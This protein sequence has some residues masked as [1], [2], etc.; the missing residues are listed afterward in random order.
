MSLQNILY[1]TIKKLGYHWYRWG[2]T[3][4]AREDL[5][6]TSIEVR[7]T[8]S[9]IVEPMFIIYDKILPRS[10]LICA[11]IVFDQTLGYKI[12]NVNNIR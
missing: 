6:Q 12:G 4:L 2:G 11:L 8:P 5:Y 7:S 10:A 9:P 1:Q 3:P